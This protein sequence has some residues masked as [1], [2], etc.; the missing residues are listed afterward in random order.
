MQYVFF[1][2]KVNKRILTIKCY[3]RKYKFGSGSN[4][5]IPDNYNQN[6]FYCNLWIIAA[7]VYQSAFKKNYQLYTAQN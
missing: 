7:S 4:K 2:Y 1:F 5:S 6:N 3:H